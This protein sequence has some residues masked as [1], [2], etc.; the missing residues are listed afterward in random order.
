MADSFKP[1]KN[2]TPADTSRIAKPIRPGIS[3]SGETARATDS[4]PAP[5]GPFATLPM[6]FGRYEIRKELG[7][8]QMGAVYLAHDVE[9]DR[10]VALK[11]AR[12]SA[13]G[14]AKLLKRMEIEAKSA[15]KVDHPQICKVYDA[16]EID[17]IRFIALQYIEGEDLK[18]YMKRLGRKREPEEAVRLIV[19]ILRAL[20]AAHEQGVIH[21][22]LKPENFMLNKKNLPV[23]MDFGL[24]RKTIASS[25]AGLTQGMI[26]GTAAYMSPE[27]ATGKAEGIDHRSDLYAVGVMLFEM[28]TG[29]WPFTGG[30]IEVMGKKV[31]QEPP[32]PLTLNPKLNPHLATVCHKMIAQ[33]KG[34]RYVTC[35]EVVASLEAI[36]LKAVVQPVPLIDVAEANSRVPEVT[37]NVDFQKDSLIA[38]S[39][40]IRKS[41]VPVG[42]KN[43]G[44]GKKQNLQKPLSSAP[45]GPLLKW[46]NEQIPLMRWTMLGGTTASLLSLA[47]ILFLPTKNGVL[48]IEID[49]PNLSVKFD[50]ST[51]TVDND[52]QPIKIGE[53]KNRTLE[54]LYNNGTSIES[55]T[56]ELTLKKGDTR[57]VRV[58]LVDGN[59]AIDGQPIVSN[60]AQRTIPQSLPKAVQFGGEAAG[61]ARE[62]VPGMKFCWC[63]PGDFVMG[64]PGATNNES[65]VSV[66]ISHG[67]W[68][69]ETEVTQSQWKSLM[70]TIP[71]QGRS[72]VKE[73]SEYAA[74]FISHG[75]EV[76]GK[77]AANSAS[78]F[79][80]RLTEQERKVGRLPEEWKYVLPTE[81]QWE[82]ACRAGTT[83]RFH[84]N[85]D[86]QSLNDFG[87]WGG[88]AGNGN[89]KSEHYAHQV[90]LKKP[91]GWGLYDMHGNV[92]EWCADWHGEKLPGGI[93]PAGPTVG[94]H[95]AHRGGGYG[96][97]APNCRSAVRGKDAP[98]YRGSHLGFRVAAVSSRPSDPLS[99]IKPADAAKKIN[100]KVVVHLE[101]KSSGGKENVYLNSEADFNDAK[102]FTI[103][104]PKERVT[105]FVK[106]GI[107]RPADHF[108]GKW[109]KVTGTVVLEQQ[110]PRVVVESPD[111]IKVVEVDP[112]TSK[113]TLTN[114]ETS[115]VKG[116]SKDGQPVSATNVVDDDWKSVFNGKDLRGWTTMTTIGPNSDAHIATAKGGWNVRSGEL[117]CETNDAGWLQLDKVYDDFEFY[118]EFF[119]PPR[120]NSGLAVHYPG[121]GVA[122]RKDLIEIQ[123]ENDPTQTRPDQ[124]CGGIYG[125]VPP[126]TQVFING[127]WNVMK[128]RL[129]SGKISVRLNDE[130]VVNT[131]VADHAALKSTPKSGH[132]CLQ[133]CIGGPGR[134]NGCKFRNIQI[135]ELENQFPVANVANGFTTTKSGLKYR[136]L[137]EGTGITPTAASTI[138]VR[139]KGWLDD[140]TVFDD[141][142]VSGKSVVLSMTKV[143]QGWAEGLKLLGNHGIIE[144][145]VPSSLGYGQKG[146]RGSIPPNS[147]LH[148]KIELLGVF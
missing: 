113:V 26:V 72:K 131:E 31:V 8:G 90:G 97:A 53:S 116:T 52:N 107:D 61:E 80:R 135:K 91:N 69:G 2:V 34:D 60:A 14:S 125:I 59:I 41:P 92:W 54:V 132:F 11:V 111:Q 115:V 23:I 32:S 143:I 126:V 82:Y 49:D 5:V 83:T 71:W 40:V 123:L 102:N 47:A 130:L 138:E 112:V 48:K 44:A 141:S 30:A 18:Q 28:L 51:I 87:W 98:G 95:R 1:P 67:F 37:P 17:G 74:S 93:D 148:F 62:L 68:L 128:V 86:D 103:F 146:V 119:L 85:V 70:Q 134:A 140:G 25:D 16:G 108:N 129:Q 12:T 110:K 77:L 117:I 99:A 45:L 38:T 20:E 81:A 109:I 64:T 35:A 66:T 114:G 57:I 55:F 19:Q 121:Q 73:G 147:T 58:T 101:V 88:F 89:A 133:N 94:S 4:V 13:S 42:K 144:L 76:D 127:Q 105:E 120:T 39:S 142:Y 84:F 36:N 124:K 33:Q 27:Q 10:L 6:Q 63:P 9:L 96:D 46:W 29:E 21:R 65:A 56:K 145:E 3:P 137:R 104:I 43:T 50:G 75:E 22:D 139:Y 106:A 100:E 7:R 79:C 122:F 24:A 118:L 136:I 15:A 78:E